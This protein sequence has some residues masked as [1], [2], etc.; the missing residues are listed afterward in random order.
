MP[1]WRYTA[2]TETSFVVKRL[3]LSSVIGTGPQ[4]EDVIRRANQQHEENV[5]GAFGLYRWG[6]F[7]SCHWVSFFIQCFWGADGDEDDDDDV[8][9]RRNWTPFLSFSVMLWWNLLTQI[10]LSEDIYPF[11]SLTYMQVN[12]PHTHTSVTL[13]PGFL[14]T[15]R[16]CFKCFIQESRK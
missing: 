14:F 13:F 16:G 1:A 3:F 12:S 9:G 15:W 2:N 7:W 10:Y 11:P 5:T 8:G 6:V 4:V